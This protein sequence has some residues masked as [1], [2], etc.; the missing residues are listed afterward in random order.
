MMTPLPCRN[1]RR[2]FWISR[3]TGPGAVLQPA[4]SEPRPTPFQ[5]AGPPGLPPDRRPRLSGGGGQPPGIV[6]SS[7]KARWPAAGLLAPVVLPS[8][9]NSS[10]VSNSV[11]QFGVN[12]AGQVIS[13]VLLAGSGL[14]EADDSALA[15]VNVLRFRPAGTSAPEFAWDTAAFYWKT[16]EP[17]RRRRP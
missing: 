5:F 14:K 8:W 11:V 10:L 16:I 4:G 17:P 12:R 15:T 6:S 1:R 13:A 3:P 7:L 9:T 2:L